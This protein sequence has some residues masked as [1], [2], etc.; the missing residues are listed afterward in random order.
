MEKNFDKI[1]QRGFVK[2]SDFGAVGDGVNDDFESLFS[3]HE[4]AN[5]HS[6]DVSADEGAVYYI[7]DFDK[8]IA[9]KTNT[10]LTGAKF[11]ID[12]TGDAVFEHRTLPL[13]L[14][15][16]DNA[17]KVFE[18][19]KLSEEFKAC[20]I[21]VGDTSIPWLKGKLDAKSLIRF[22]NANHRDFIRFGSNVNSGNPRTDCLLVDTDGTI[23]T[24]TPV[25]F[26]FSDVTKIEIFR[27]DDTP[28]TIKGG[29]FESI[30]CR[31]VEAT[32]FEN[33]WRGYYR[34]FKITRSN[35]TIS[36]MTHR[37]LD[38]PFISDTGY[39][40][41]EDGKLSQSYP[42]YGFVY[43]YNTYNSYAKN[44]ALCGHTT[45]YEDKPTSTKPVP[46][47]SYDLVIEYSSHVYCENITNGVDI[48]DTRYWGIMSSNGAKNME[49]KNCSMSRF[50]AHRGFWNARLIGCT[51]GQT[52]NVIGGG[53]LEVIDT[54]R[55]RG[56]HFIALRG[57]YGATFNGDIIL[58]NCKY[59]AKKTYRGIKT[60][61]YC[62]KGVVLIACGFHT[63]VEKFL[64]WDFGYT[65]H[66][67]RNIYI[68][69]FETSLPD[70]TYIFN[71][72]GNE[73]FD[74]NHKNAYRITESISFK[75]SP[76]LPISIS[77]ECTCLWEIPTDTKE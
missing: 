28:I 71:K 38:E 12:D 21:N 66:M 15:E 45:Y 20:P 59:L 67:P 9:V 50:D 70:S 1:I 39:G 32:G 69:N 64:E 34:R 75:N 43:F 6:L 19:E 48:N 27:T 40:R 7:H 35:T 76:M 44:L 18:G 46:M 16:K 2:Y 37:I 25:A 57:D 22:T 23:D 72:I 24:D 42:Y 68:E 51:F 54:T 36:N 31:A 8:S 77:K 10:D 73:G 63:D 3:A 17:A 33:K 53:K 14:A 49:F 41:G 55:T 60:D 61:E 11:I 26:D 13:F 4:F 29:Y 58:K 62:E 52:I 74:K 5:E 30:C 65:C 47:G 56:T